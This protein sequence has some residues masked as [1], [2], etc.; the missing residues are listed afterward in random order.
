MRFFLALLLVHPS[1]TAQ[2][3]DAPDENLRQIL[4]LT[5]AQIL[6]S[7]RSLTVAQQSRLNQ[8][9]VPSIATIWPRSRFGSELW[10][11]TSGPA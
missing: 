5:D 6:Q 1:L 4:S 11:R 8:L 9:S 7:K 3:G 2:A 10:T